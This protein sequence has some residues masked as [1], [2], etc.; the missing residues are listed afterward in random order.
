MFKL[1]DEFLV[2]MGLSEMPAE[3]K[4]AFLDHVES[5]MDRRIGEKI[6]E[7][8]TDEQFDEFTK[9]S[10]AD[11]EAVNRVLT[12]I[13]DWQNDRIFQSLVAATGLAADD[14][15]LLNQYAS[16]M[17]ISQNVPNYSEIVNAEVGKITAEVRANREQIIAAI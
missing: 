3:K 4:Q 14:A 13:G 7:V 6:S 16:M 17:W 10:D 9:V 12:K 11:A 2:E 8:L 5:E 15:T 1:N